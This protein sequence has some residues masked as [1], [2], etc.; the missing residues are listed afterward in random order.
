MLGFLKKKKI[1]LKMPINGKLINITEVPDAVFSQKMLGDGFA[2]EPSE[3][4]VYS[5]INGKVIQKFPTNHALGLET[6]E[7]LEI[8]I[9]FGLD[10]VE[11]KG[12]GFK[13]LV[14]VGDVITAGQALLEVDLEFLKENNKPSVT[15]IIFTNFDKI[16][17][18]DAKYGEIAAKSDCCEI[19]LN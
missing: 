10:T 6:E 14:E 18:F 3:G 17:K 2:I 1:I 19:I 16:K 12:E 5:P 8:L 7:G 9:H 11:L 4:I 13:N 15:P